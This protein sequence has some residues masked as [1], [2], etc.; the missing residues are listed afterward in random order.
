MPGREKW[1]RILKN[2]KEFTMVTI[3]F[4]LGVGFLAGGLAGFNC[5]LIW[6]E[7]MVNHKAREKQRKGR[8]V[9]Y[10]F[11]DDDDLPPVRRRGRCRH[12]DE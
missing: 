10:I 7:G 8:K 6:I 12:D 11:D 2:R 3:L 4:L 9:K 5:A 1:S